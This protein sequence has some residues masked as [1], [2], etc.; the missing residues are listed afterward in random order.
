MLCM[1][2]YQIVLEIFQEQ[3]GERNHIVVVLGNFLKGDVVRLKPSNWLAGFS[4]SI[5]HHSLRLVETQVPAAA[6]L[7]FGCNITS[8]AGDPISW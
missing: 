2:F 7:P 4:F 8:A 1:C 5:Q 6:T 3:N